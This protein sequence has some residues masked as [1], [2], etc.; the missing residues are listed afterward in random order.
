MLFIGNS[1]V[2]GLFTVSRRQLLVSKMAFSNLW[3]NAN[4]PME[5][6]Y[7]NPR[8]NRYDNGPGGDLDDKC[9]P[10]SRHQGSGRVDSNTNYSIYLKNIEPH[11]TPE[12]LRTMSQDWGQP[13]NVKKFTTTTGMV[14]FKTLA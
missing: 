2:L 3:P 5:D 10:G 8:T 6:S 9:Q 13:Q 14:W 7:K 12:G 11:T 4:N 1:H